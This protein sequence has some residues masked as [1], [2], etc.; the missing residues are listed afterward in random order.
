[1]NPETLQLIAV[2]IWAML[3]ISMIVILT[4][5]VVSQR[6][7]DRR[8][9][10][11][12]LAQPPEFVVDISKS[13]IYPPSRDIWVVGGETSKSKARRKA[14]DK[15]KKEWSRACERARSG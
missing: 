15:Y 8:E 7:R 12:Y 3:P 2:G 10:R 4:W 11:E 14:Y 1:M 9:L 6:L 5:A 13:P